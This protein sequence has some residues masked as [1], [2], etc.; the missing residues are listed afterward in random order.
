MAQ[1]MKIGIA[2]GSG[3]A[4]GWAHVGALRQ[5]TAYGI[6][7]HCVAGTSIGALVGGVYCAGHLESLVDLAEHLDWRRVMQ[8]F[9]EMRLQKSGILTGRNVVNLLR[10]DD[11]IGSAAF[12]DLQTPFAAIATDIEAERAVTLRTGSVVEAIRASIAIPGIFTPVRNGS[13][14]LVDGGMADPLPIRLCR[15]MG[16]DLVIAIDINLNRAEADT[17]KPAPVP[18]ARPSP[19]I[20]RIMESVGKRMPQVH[21]ELSDLI[22]RWF[23]PQKT[24]RSEPSIIEVLTRSVRLMENQITRKILDQTP[25]D[26]LIQPC[27]GHISTLDFYR[28]AEIIQTGADAVLKEKEALEMALQRTLP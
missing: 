18:P 9:L 22:T 16:A 1:E 14:L 12:E 20:Q 21:G 25:P 15:A 7:P 3:G 13:Q 26:I 27:V 23:T 11:M 24:V 6:R 8:L 4:R 2:L 19:R 10:A 28:G 5:L 17:V